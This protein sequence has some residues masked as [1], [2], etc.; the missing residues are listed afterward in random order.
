MKVN[1]TSARRTVKDEVY[2]GAW[3]T[4]NWKR[5]IWNTSSPNDGWVR[6]ETLC[7]AIA[8]HS[9]FTQHEVRIL[10]GVAVHDGRLH[11]EEN[12]VR[13]NSQLPDDFGHRI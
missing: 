5:H 8:E 2:Y 11:K 10:L 6:V 7:S 1:E 13:W 4:I 3:E 9:S 12:R